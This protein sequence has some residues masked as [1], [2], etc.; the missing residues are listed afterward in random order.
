M[1][2]GFEDVEEAIMRWCKDARAGRRHVGVTFVRVFG[3]LVAANVEIGRVATLSNGDNVAVQAATAV[4]AKVQES[5]VVES[6]G[7]QDLTPLRSEFGEMNI[8]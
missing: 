1:Q 4:K 2:G 8:T 7:G 6:G 5:M 3:D